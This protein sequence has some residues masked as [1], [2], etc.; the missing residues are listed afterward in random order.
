MNS[1]KVQEFAEPGEQ[2]GVTLNAGLSKHPYS[3]SNGME[4]AEHQCDVLSKDCHF[5]ASGEHRMGDICALSY[6]SAKQL[7]C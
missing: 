6:L 2:I 4:V 5:S 1:S 3:A 7:R